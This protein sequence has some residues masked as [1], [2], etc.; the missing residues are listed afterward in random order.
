M[1]LVTVGLSIQFWQRHF[2]WG[3]FFFWTTQNLSNVLSFRLIYFGLTSSNNC[4]TEPAS[5]IKCS[6]SRTETSDILKS[7]SHFKIGS[8]SYYVCFCFTLIIICMHITS[9]LKQHCL[10]RHIII[11]TDLYTGGESYSHILS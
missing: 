11:T 6:S 3:S 5:K 7:Y 9:T 4:F 10:T 8:H 1:F 2:L